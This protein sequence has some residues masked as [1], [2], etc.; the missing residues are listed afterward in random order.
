MK[1]TT[2]GDVA[3]YTFFSIAGLFVGGE[4]GLLT[5]ASAAKRTISKDPETKARIERAFRGLRADIRRKE[6]E[7]LESGKG[8]S[9][10][11]DPT[12]S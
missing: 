8:G 6:I 10:L 11:F 7:M 1:P 3:A 12:W 9:A 4:V 5:G 2:A